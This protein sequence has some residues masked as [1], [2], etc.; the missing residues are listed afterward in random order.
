MA[1]ARARFRTRCFAAFSVAYRDAV[2]SGVDAAGFEADAVG[3]LADHFAGFNANAGGVLP[4][5]HA[6]AA[7]VGAAGERTALQFP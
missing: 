2:L 3:A 1:P 5:L 7:A 6:Y 4:T